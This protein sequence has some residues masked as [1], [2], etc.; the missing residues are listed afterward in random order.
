MTPTEIE[1]LQLSEAQE[2]LLVLLNNAPNREVPARKLDGRTVKALREAKLVYEKNGFVG[3]NG[4]GILFFK[5]R[6]QDRHD[7]K[8]SVM[9][10][11]AIDVLEKLAP[12]EEDIGVG[13]EGRSDGR[14][15]MTALHVDIMAGYRRWISKNLLKTR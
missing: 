8:P 15:G 9:A 12:E 4:M 14:Y 2:D 7:L 11:W 10:H 5:A 13:Y 3:A 1:E 6:L